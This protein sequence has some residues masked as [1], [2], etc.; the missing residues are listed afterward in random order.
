MSRS[1]TT[2][3]GSNSN[4]STNSMQQALSTILSGKVSI[5]DLEGFSEEQRAQLT[6]QLGEVGKANR[7]A[8][9]LATTK[10]QAKFVT[11][12]ASGRRVLQIQLEGQG[13]GARKQIAPEYFSDDVVAE[14]KRVIAAGDPGE[15]PEPAAAEK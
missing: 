15:A 2:S 9:R 3:G 13:K 4:S 8:S 6:A 12:R 10:L 14:A 11:A 7:V 1:K 5:H